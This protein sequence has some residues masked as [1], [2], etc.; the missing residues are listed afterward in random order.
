MRK[1][2]SITAITFTLLAASL[3]PQLASASIPLNQ[4]WYQPRPDDHTPLILAHQGGEKEYPSN[5]MLAFTK[6]HWAGA[7]A[8]DTDVQATKDGV[9][10]LFHDDTLDYRTN[11]TGAIADKTFAELQSVDFAYNWT[12]DNGATYPYRGKGIHVATARDLLG[13]FPYDRVGMEI[14]P[15]SAAVAQSLCTLIKQYGA[16]NRVLISSTAQTQMDAFRTACPTVATSATQSE[17]EQF[18]Y[19]QQTGTIPECF[20][21]PYSSLQLPETSGNITVLTPAFVAD[22]HKA[23]LRV[24]AWTIDTTEQA[25]HFIDMGVDGINVNYPKRIIDWLEAKS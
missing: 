15:Q 21:P 10:V 4:A 13:D 9:L 25:Q 12:P 24:Y 8:L 16:Q 2:I 19:M 18:L 5:S 22:A 7:D 14:K 1:I 3:F 17:A 6:A 11:G 20:K 23:H